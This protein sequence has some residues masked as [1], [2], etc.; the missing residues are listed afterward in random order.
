MRFV[1]AKNHEPALIVEAPSELDA[2]LW[3]LRHGYDRF[4][5]SPESIDAGHAALVEALTHKFITEGE[6]ADEAARKATIGSGPA[7]SEVLAARL[8][9]V[10]VPHQEP[11]PRL[12]NSRASENAGKSTRRINERTAERWSGEIMEPARPTRVPR[13]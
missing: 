11:D 5:R 8:Q 7:P 2:G 10:E 9:F 1:L 12:L 13:S 4:T 6:P 3:A